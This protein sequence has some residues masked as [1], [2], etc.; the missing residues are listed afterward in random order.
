MDDYFNISVIF[1]ESTVFLIFFFISWAIHD[2][3]LCKGVCVL[4][5]SCT[6]EYSCHMI[7]F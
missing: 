2:F 7:M 4:H 3:S 5:G 1:I 6:I